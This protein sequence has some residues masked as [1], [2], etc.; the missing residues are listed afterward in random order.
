MS[1]NSGINQRVRSQTFFNNT[2]NED[3]S[4]QETNLNL[5]ANLKYVQ[6]Y[7]TNYINTVG[8]YLN[9]LNPNFQGS[10]TSTSGGNIRINSLSVPTISGSSNFIYTPTINN[11]NF[12]EYDVIGELKILIDN[13]P[14]SNFVLCN[15]AL[16]SINTYPKLFQLIGYSFGGSGGYYNLPNFQ[17]SY[18]IGGNGTINNL[19][20]S[21]FA[22]GNGQ[23]GATNNYLNHYD[24][25]NSLLAEIPSHSHNYI[26]NG[27]N[28]PVPYDYDKVLFINALPIPSQLIVSNLGQSD[29]LT[30]NSQININISESGTNIIPQTIGGLP[31]VN[32]TIPY[33]AT[34]I[35]ICCQ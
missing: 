5:I 19:A 33:V 20:G 15:G 13:T 26:D 11:T 9:I 2:I 21:N 29:I 35:F 6:D 34:F 25:T 4:I 12:F 32:I 23:S 18:P 8:G 7:I 16:L 22:T 1:Y 3:Y 24:L 28:H 30:T 27:H 10:M 17:S 14:P 31:G